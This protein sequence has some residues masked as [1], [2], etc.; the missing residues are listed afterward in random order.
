MSRHLFS[1]C[2]QS[3]INSDFPKPQGSFSKL[4]SPLLWQP[5]SEP[6]H[7]LW[8][9]ARLNPTSLSMMIQFQTLKFLK[10][11]QLILFSRCCKTSFELR[12]QSK[13]Q[14]KGGIITLKTNFPT[15]KPKSNIMNQLDLYFSTFWMI[16][17]NNQLK[18]NLTKFIKILETL[19]KIINSK[20]KLS[21]KKIAKLLCFGFH[22]N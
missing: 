3:L 7:P 20:F 6:Q 16:R 1:L 11:Y 4:I 13:R 21:L 10:I 22:S 19:L 14:Q 18:T 5:F 15:L 9:W 12:P 2:I 8:T 17:P